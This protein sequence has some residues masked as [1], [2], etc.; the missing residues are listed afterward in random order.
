MKNYPDVFAV[1]DKKMVM[2][3]DG[4]FALYS[5]EEVIQLTNEGKI[6]LEYPRSKGGRIADMTQK[7]ALVF[8]E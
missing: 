5:S 1:S 4:S 3:M 7:P 6:K 2:K 8:T